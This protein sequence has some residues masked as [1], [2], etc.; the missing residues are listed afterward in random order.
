MLCKRIAIQMNTETHPINCKV[1]SKFI[2]PPSHSLLIWG[3]FYIAYKLFWDNNYNNNKHTKQKID[4]YGANI[5]Y[6]M[7][8][9]KKE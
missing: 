4:I 2:L 5:F 8:N 3:L 7:T 1:C 9:Q 6:K